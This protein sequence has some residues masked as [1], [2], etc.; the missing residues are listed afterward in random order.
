ML[1]ME[2]YLAGVRAVAWLE[3]IMGQ[4]QQ[5]SSKK[6][7]LTDVHVHVHVHVHVC[8]IL[9]HVCVHIVHYN[10]NCGHKTALLCTNTA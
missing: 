8:G 4:I 9:E 7:P 2:G 5:S 3:E 1:F 6:P 10:Y